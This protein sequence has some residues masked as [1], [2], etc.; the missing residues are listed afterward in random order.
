VTSGEVVGGIFLTGDQLLGVEQLSVSTGSDLVNNGGLEINHDTSGNVLSGSG[1]GEESVEGVVATSDGL[2]RGHLSVRL[3]TVLEAVKLPTGV[4]DLNS[5]LSNV[6][7]D[8]FS[9]WLLLYLLNCFKL[10]QQL[11]ERFK[12]CAFLA[13]FE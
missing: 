2:V 6:D 9:H 8:N 3:D 4:S 13:L 10:I 1:L 5:G 7:T 11:F 12:F